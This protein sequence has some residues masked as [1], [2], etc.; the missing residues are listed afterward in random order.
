[1]ILT[2]HNVSSKDQ[3][4]SSAMVDQNG[5]ETIGNVRGVYVIYPAAAG[6]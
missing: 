3:G 5:Q 1:M 6:L 2:K 4:K